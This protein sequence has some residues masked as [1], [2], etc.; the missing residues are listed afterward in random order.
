MSNKDTLEWIVRR[1][2]VDALAIVEN[3]VDLRP[4]PYRYLTVVAER[5]MGSERV[6][7]AVAAA[8]MLVPWGWDLLN[9]TEFFDRSAYAFL[10]R[11][12]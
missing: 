2:I 10:T 1:R 6:T 5:G 11:R 9:V 3:R 12:G 7:L 8:E 4:Y